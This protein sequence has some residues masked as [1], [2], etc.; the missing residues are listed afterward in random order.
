MAKIKILRDLEI[1]N[2]SEDFEY[3]FNFLFLSGNTLIIPKFQRSY[4]WDCENNINDIIYDLFYEYNSKKNEFEYFMGT[5]AI[6]NEKTKPNEIYSIIDGQQRI[7]TLLIIRMCLYFIANEKHNIDIVDEKQLNFIKDIRHPN[8]EIAV[9]KKLEK[10]DISKWKSIMAE[11]KKINHVYD[12]LSETLYDLNLINEENLRFLASDFFGKIN[13]AILWIEGNEIEQIYE[14]INYKSKELSPWELFI[15]KMYLLSSQFGVFSEE[16]IELFLN[17]IIKL[18]ERFV[19]IVNEKKR[20][21]GLFVRIMSSIYFREKI[22]SENSKKIF[23]YRDLNKKMKESIK[24]ENDFSNYIKGLEQIIKKINELFDN[25][26]KSNKID[27]LIIKSFLSTSPVYI[28]AILNNNSS[29]MIKRLFFDYLYSH[30]YRT[31][32]VSNGNKWD[33]VFDRYFIGNAISNKNDLSLDDFLKNTEGKMAYG[34]YDKKMLKFILVFNEIQETK[35]K[36]FKGIKN[37]TLK[38]A[39]DLLISNSHDIEHIYSRKPKEI[40]PD[41][42]ESAL[43]NSLGN[44]TLIEKEINGECESKS[45]GEKRE[46]YAKSHLSIQHFSE[47]NS[48]LDLGILKERERNMLKKLF[49][50]F[51]K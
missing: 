28:Y 1:N 5:L 43:K 47:K 40:V 16:E 12:F 11:N 48:N 3:N 39:A 44:L 36:K 17:E 46:H 18:E 34:W 23:S 50:T 15:N 4:V 51:N 14:N 19:T 49:E 8:D 20:T 26:S 32:A 45:Y 38:K 31:K 27:N 6:N 29:K 41:L 2:Q 24:T 13:F 30:P 21:E 35:D 9:L 42:E 22:G 25:I 10:S 33:D 7:T 37:I